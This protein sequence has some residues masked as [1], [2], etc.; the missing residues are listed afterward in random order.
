MPQ[1]AVDASPDET[2]R[3]KLWLRNEYIDK[4][5]STTEIA[6]ELN[7]SPPTV[8]RWLHRHEIESRGRGEAQTDGQTGPLRNESWLHR[9]Y[10]ECQRSQIDIAGELGVSQVTVSKWLDRHGITS[11]TDSGVSTR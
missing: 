8:S 10:V 1:S 2:Y 9:Q 4:K 11:S 5:R 3:D 7:I 6:A